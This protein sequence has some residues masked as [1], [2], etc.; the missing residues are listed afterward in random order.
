M[1]A[2]LVVGKIGPSPMR[3]FAA[4][5]ARAELTFQ[6]T[7]RDAIVEFAQGLPYHAQLLCLMSARSA[8]R[9]QSRDVA[10][11]D[12]RYAVE[13]AA[14]EAEARIRE[15]YVLA[16]GTPAE[17]AF[18]DALYRAARAKSDE[19]GSFTAA[20]VAAVVGDDALPALQASL[21]TLLGPERGAVLRRIDRA[22]GERYQFASQ[23]LRHYVLV[24]QVLQRGLI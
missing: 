9:R 10:P 4:G 3:T 11:E 8:I 22:D 2:T 15:A 7:V 24:R 16:V 12:F 21:K 1:I 18:E 14:E 13:R 23:M 5:E 19:F 6:P 20:D 17:P